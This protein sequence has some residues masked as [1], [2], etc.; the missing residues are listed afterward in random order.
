MENGL[1]LTTITG[2]LAVVTPLSLCEQGILALLVLGDLVGADSTRLDLLA[3]PIILETTYV[4]FLQALP[5]QSVI[6][7][8]QMSPIVESLSSFLID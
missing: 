7:P 6:P 5:L 4:C 3:P 8:N 1:C 2:L